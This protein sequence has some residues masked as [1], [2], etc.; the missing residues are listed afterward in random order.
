MKRQ[1]TTKQAFNSLMK[2]FEKMSDIIIDTY[3][4]EFFN[5]TYKI[6]DSLKAFEIIKKKRINVDDFLWQTRVL[7]HSY[8]YY[9]KQWCI[10]NKPII[11]K[12]HEK[13]LTKKEFDFLQEIL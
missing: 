12:E 11:D 2:T 8:A 1:L 6:R 7:K 5:K 10:A 13:L 9:K 3:S 4:V